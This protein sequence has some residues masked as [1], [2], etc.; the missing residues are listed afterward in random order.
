MTNKE[1]LDNIIRYLR[2][3]RDVPTQVAESIRTLTWGIYRLEYQ[4]DILDRMVEMILGKE[5]IEKMKRELHRKL[6]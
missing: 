2:G 1:A 3:C 6:E 5:Y 4:K